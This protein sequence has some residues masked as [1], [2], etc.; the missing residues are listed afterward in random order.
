M[1]GLMPPSDGSVALQPMLVRHDVSRERAASDRLRLEFPVRLLE[2]TKGMTQTYA[3][4]LSAKLLVFVC[5]TLSVGNS[6]TDPLRKRWIVLE[7]SCVFDE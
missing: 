5:L 3:A 2:E 1:F 7:G 6:Q 4:G